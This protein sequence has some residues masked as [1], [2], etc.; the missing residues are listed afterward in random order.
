MRAPT[1]VL[2]ATDHR[3]WDVPSGLWVM[4]QGWY[5]L[6]FVHW[7]VPADALRPLIPEAL[8]VDT[9]ERTAWLGIIPFDLRMRPRG[10][11]TLSHFPEL[12]CRTYVVHRDKPGIFFFSLDAGS[13][14]AVWGARKFFLLPYFYAEMKIH[15]EKL[16][17]RAQGARQILAK[18]GN[19]KKAA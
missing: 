7:P 13:R 18:A 6:L 17:L 15:I 4:M 10:L 1:D 9:F 16:P 2:D 3:P 19:R 14:L 8:A 12:N 5:D 11:P